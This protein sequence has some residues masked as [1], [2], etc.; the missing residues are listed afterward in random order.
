[1]TFA[2][3]RDESADAGKPRPALK[4]SNALYYRKHTKTAVGVPGTLRLSERRLSFH[5]KGKGPDYIWDLASVSVERFRGRVNGGIKIV[6]ED[7]ENEHV[8]TRVNERSYERIRDAIDEAKF[9]GE[10]KNLRR[11][12]MTA[13]ANTG[14][15]LSE[16]LSF[17]E[18]PRLPQRKP[19]PLLLVPFRFIF[20]V[21]LRFVATVYKLL[22]GRRL[23]GPRNIHDALRGVL[24]TM[25][26]IL[27]ASRETMSER[28][29]KIIAK[30]VESIHG[31]LTKIQMIVKRE[32]SAFTSQGSVTDSLVN[33][34]SLLERTGFSISWA[35]SYISYIFFRIRR[36][37]NIP[38]YQWT[39]RPQQHPASVPHAV[40]DANDRVVSLMEVAGREKFSPDVIAESKRIQLLLNNIKHI[41]VNHQD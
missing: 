22:T 18:G 36:A 23:G 20:I 40:K 9:D 6:G 29:V 3:E 12:S 21:V 30:D 16:S 38:M 27:A 17:V 37:L 34:G 25:N 1:M 19:L 31:A 4:I 2:E 5:H 11:A 39:L 8:I 28:K 10:M 41:S 24:T 32:Q 35:M 33:T 7:A 14:V 13:A 15:S 26:P